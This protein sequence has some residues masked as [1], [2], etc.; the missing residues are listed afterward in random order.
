M[1]RAS[2]S[3][4]VLLMYVEPCVAIIFRN[5]A[6]SEPGRDRILSTDATKSY[7]M[8]TNSAETRQVAGVTVLSPNGGEDWRVGTAQTISWADSGVANVKIECTTDNGTSWTTIVASTPGAS[9]NF[10]WTVPN[11]LSEQCKVKI[12]DVSNGAVS[13][14]SDDVFFV[15]LPLRI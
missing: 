12:S 5:S 13:D 6:I 8:H 4:I 15:T 10:A 7:G 14:A 11:T 9:G 2:L 3:L 1:T